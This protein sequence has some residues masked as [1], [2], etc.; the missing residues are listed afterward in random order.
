MNRLPHQL[1][2]VFALFWVEIVVGV[3]GKGT[4]GIGV[5]GVEWRRC[6]GEEPIINVVGDERCGE[7]AKI[8][9]EGAGYGVDIK[10]RIG[11]VVII[12]TFKAFFDLLNLAVAAGFT[13]DAFNF[14]AC[15][16]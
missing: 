15:T 11:D 4:A 6:R 8:L 12:A 16:P 13:V 5:V 10:V 1:D 3:G 9:F 2:A 7:F 14:H